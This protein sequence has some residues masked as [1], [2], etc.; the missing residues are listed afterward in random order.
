MTQALP[1][2]G[3]RIRVLSMP[4]DPCPIPS[5]TTGTVKAVYLDRY[6]H[7]HQ[8]VVKW[9]IPRSLMLVCGVDEFEVLA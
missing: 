2:P 6:Q 3:Q 9:D 4:A 7:R 8:I 1:E 5:G